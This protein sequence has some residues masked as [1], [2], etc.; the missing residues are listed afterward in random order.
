MKKNLNEI[1]DEITP[2]ELD[3]F[4]DELKAE[5]L[6]DEVM[7]SIKGKVYAK[8]NI[9]KA[10]KVKKEGRTPRAV[11]L[12]VGALAACF[13]VIIG[14]IALLPTLREEDPADVITPSGDEV[15]TPP[16]GDVVP[17]NEPYEPPQIY[18]PVVSD[19][20]SGSSLE[21]IVG[22][23]IGANTASPPIF[24]FFGGP[25]AVKARVVKAHPDIYYKID[26]DSERKPKAYR[27]IQMETLEVIAGSATMPR[28][29]L[30]LIP[31]ADYVDMS[32]YDSL[33]ISM[34]QVGTEKYLLKN[35]TQNRLEYFDLLMFAD[36]TD[37]PDLG[38]IIAISDGVFDESLWQNENWNYGYQFARDYLDEPDR[39]TSY[40]VVR[41][42]A[43]EEEIIAKIKEDRENYRIIPVI[44]L[45]H[46]NEEINAIFEYVKPFENGVFAQTL[47][48]SHGYSSI[49]F[50][51][52]VN[53]CQT[54]ERYVIV[55]DIERITYPEVTYTNEDIAKLEDLSAVVA[56]KVAEYKETTPMPPRIDTEEMEELIGLNVFAWYVKDADKLYGVIKTA[57]VYEGIYND[58][59]YT[60]D[61]V[62]FYDDVYVL[63]DMT[64]NT[65]T[66]MDRNT[67]INTVKDNR[68]VYAGDYELPIG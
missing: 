33:L 46:E 16:D 43:S 49:I 26:V 36:S 8:T 35:D 31:D 54:E 23:S 11:W 66:E 34:T 32:I 21:F 1:F 45:N 61:N 28:D 59:N 60:Y 68:N 64:E 55:L 63:Y 29:F 5:K 19:L 67:L 17:P 48:A 30:Y 51:R 56:A 25:F 18:E 12:R 7:T 27:L 52:F 2:E 22:S 42:G 15:V 37:H 47:Y 44:T 39:Y 65:V 53:G 41:R 57:W 62:R 38:S 40:L 4:S 9:E 50:T 6:S 14:T 20:P 10:V 24:G 3:K 13:A 58:G